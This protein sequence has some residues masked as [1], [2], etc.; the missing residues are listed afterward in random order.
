M[1]S[2]WFVVRNMLCVT[3][4]LV[5]GTRDHRWPLVSQVGEREGGEGGWIDGPDGPFS[6][7][8]LHPFIYCLHCQHPPDHK[9]PPSVLS[10]LGVT[11]SPPCHC[12]W[13]RLSPGAHYTHNEGLY[14]T[15]SSSPDEKFED[16]DTHWE[17]T[18]RT[19]GAFCTVFFTTKAL[20][21]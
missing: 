14:N 8:L 6:H 18:K 9:P 15:I 16:G 10:P 19:P 12:L 21:I 20:H 2:K 3:G 1:W 13:M 5:G 11:P 7:S 4:G 17:I